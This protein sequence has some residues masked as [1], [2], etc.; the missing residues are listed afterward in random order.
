MD[1]KN[2]L[3]LALDLIQS[4]LYLRKF[5]HFQYNVLYHP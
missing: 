4:F 3:Q 2:V 1:K 5:L